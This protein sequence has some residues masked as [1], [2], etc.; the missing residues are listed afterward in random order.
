[1]SA[2]STASL[3]QHE[4]SDIKYI[5]KPNILI[6]QTT[7][8]ATPKGC[9]TDC[10]TCCNSSS[11]AYGQAQ[12]FP[13]TSLPSNPLKATND[14]IPLVDFT[15]N[16]PSPSSHPVKE[17]V[18]ATVEQFKNWHFEA[19]LRSPLLGFQLDLSY[20]HLKHPSIKDIPLSIPQYN[21]LV[22]VILDNPYIPGSD[23][24]S[25]KVLFNPFSY[26]YPHRPCPSISK[27]RLLS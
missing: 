23:V 15:G 14:A 13:I 21:N 9:M 5:Q 25:I 17:R 3:S 7:M 4:H 6:F 12:V 8:S 18:I 22:R 24:D 10:L 27:P 26:S 16:S 11:P 2:G 19:F 1:M 20:Q